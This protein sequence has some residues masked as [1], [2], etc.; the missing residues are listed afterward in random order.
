MTDVTLNCFRFFIATLSFT[1]RIATRKYNYWR[2]GLLQSGIISRASYGLDFSKTFST[3][4][5]M[6]VLPNIEERSL[7]HCC[8]G[9]AISIT[10]L[11][12]C[13]GKRVGGG[14]CVRA[15]VCGCEFS[16]AGVCL[17]AC[18]LTNPA[19]NVPS[20]RHLRPLINSTLFGKK[21]LLIVKGS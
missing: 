1:I 4:Q 18:S 13:A 21:V 12:V 16:G 14:M 15:C 3:R 19:R 8:R 2:C 6:Y 7:N 17:H 20:Y 10:Y 9:K 11:C 5:A